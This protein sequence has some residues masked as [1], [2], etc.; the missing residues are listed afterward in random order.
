MPPS[1]SATC[2]LIPAVIQGNIYF[3]YIKKKVH[4]LYGMNSYANSNDSIRVVTPL[5]KQKGSSM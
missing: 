4:D 5:P 2:L 3:K 1:S